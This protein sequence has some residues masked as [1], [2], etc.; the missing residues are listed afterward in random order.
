MKSFTGSR[1]PSKSMA[2][3]D[4]E[5]KIG[6][7]M[8]FSAILGC[9]TFQERQHSRKTVA[10]SGI[11]KYIVPNVSGCIH[12]LRFVRSGPSNMHRCRVFLFALA[13]LFLFY[14]CCLLDDRKGCSPICKSTAA[15]DHPNLG[16]SLTKWVGWTKTKW[17]CF[18]FFLFRF[19]ISGIIKM[20]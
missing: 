4:L 19:L 2:L 8:D 10:P 17:M 3:D 6:V 18:C 7:F 14:R 13:G 20:L 5:R 11:C 9:D 12:E 16:N 1:L 15:S